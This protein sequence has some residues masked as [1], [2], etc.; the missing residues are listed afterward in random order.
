MSGPV[1]D[2]LGGKAA[3]ADCAS[4]W[5]IPAWN[6]AACPVPGRSYWAYIS[7]MVAGGKAG[8]AAAVHVCA[9]RDAFLQLDDLEAA[10]P[11]GLAGRRGLAFAA[12]LHGLLD[13]ARFHDGTSFPSNGGLA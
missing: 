10:L 7:L 4:L 12:G 5:R 11:L 1:R 9:R 13:L 6:G 2:L 8:P 3:P